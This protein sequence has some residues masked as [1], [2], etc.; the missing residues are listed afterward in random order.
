MPCRGQA[1]GPGSLR[2]VAL[3]ACEI[4][5]AMGLLCLREVVFRSKVMLF[6]VD[7]PCNRII[8]LTICV[9]VLGF[10]DDS[11]MNERHTPHA[12]DEL[13]GPFSSSQICKPQ[14]FFLCCLR[15]ELAHETKRGYA[16][17]VQSSSSA[18]TAVSYSYVVGSKH[19]NISSLPAESDDVW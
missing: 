19:E 9:L 14:E 5:E 18:I 3:W 13:C 2:S 15:V 1:A 4:C 16:I 11:F 6:V 10:G 12:R 17:A 7:S 8:L